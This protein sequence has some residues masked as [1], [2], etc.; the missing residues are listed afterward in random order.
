MSLLAQIVS[1]RI[2]AEVLRILFL[3]SSVRLH[4][5]EIARRADASIA[6]VRQELQRLTRLDLLTRIADGNRVYFQANTDH[7]L[8]VDIH[9]LVMKTVGLVGLLRDA[10]QDERVQVAFVFGSVARGEAT[11]HSDVDLMVIGKLGLR[12]LSRLLSGQAEQLGREINSHV[13]RPGEVR[14]RLATEDHFLQSVMDSPKLF[15][16]G[17]DDDFA[18]L[19]NQRLVET[20]Q[21]QS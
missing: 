18:A 14:R 4:L 12:D 1:S 10:L 19:G 7:P 9:N 17:S 16:I 21:D 11:A 5:R 2:R 13:L 15:V 6:A 20:A 8:Y 3:D